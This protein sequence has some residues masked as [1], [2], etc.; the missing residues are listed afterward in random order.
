V[1][2][3]IASG[4]FGERVP[5][6]SG[7]EVGRLAQDINR[8][9][10]RL[11][12]MVADLHDARTQAEEALRIRQDL[13]ANVS[14]ELRTPLAVLQ[15]QLEALTLRERVAA[16]SARG[17]DVLLPA[18]TLEA[19][20]GEARRLESLIDDLFAL[21][22]AQ[23]GGLEVTCRP[24]D[25]AAIVDDVVGLMSPLARREAA[26]ALSADI[27][28]G[29]PPALADAD[30]LRQILANLVRNAIRHTPEGGIIVV[31][32]R[33]TQD[34][35]AICVADTG[36]G[37]DPEHLPHVWDRFYRADP[38]RAR[39]TGGAGLGLAIVRE[40]VEMMGGSVAAASVPGE[41]SRF[42]VY[43]PTVI[44]TTAEER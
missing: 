22:R 11:E 43:L 15:A 24:V 12:R 21:S 39:D 1:A 37:I 34:R 29:L 7:N 13:V 3:A 4:N 42:W 41:G 40:L 35:I 26:V 19:L 44:S 38:S 30:R 5:V 8:M 17:D 27:P 2:R 31:S 16:G 25:V 10:E 33:P 18:A 14:H 36:E 23:S 28:P 32:A 6:R 20:R 9:A